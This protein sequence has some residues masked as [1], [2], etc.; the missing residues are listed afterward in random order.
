VKKMRRKL[1]SAKDLEPTSPIFSRDHMSESEKEE[2]F[3]NRQADFKRNFGILN[4]LIKSDELSEVKRDTCYED[5]ILMTLIHNV[6]NFPKE[7]FNK[8]MV[9]SIKEEIDKN[10]IPVDYLR[11]SLSAYKD[12]TLE[13]RRCKE[14]KEMVDYAISTWKVNENYVQSRT[15][16]IEHIEYVDCDKNK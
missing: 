6:Q 14:M 13:E 7:V 4:R 12:F 8:N 5:F 10:N 2:R 15:G 9:M 1:I 3:K 16:K 11:I